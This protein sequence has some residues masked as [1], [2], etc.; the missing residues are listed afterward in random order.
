MN[1]RINK[2]DVQASESKISSDAQ[3][4]LCTRLEGQGT[5]V[6]FYDPSIRIA[7]LFHYLLPSAR[8]KENLRPYQY[9]DTG[10]EKTLFSMI[11]AGSE[12]DRIIIKISGA[13]VTGNPEQ[14]IF[15]VSMLAVKT[16]GN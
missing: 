9:A 16:N 15:R 3:D 7:G 8:E 14:D 13:A 5:A 10:I 2:M 11:D 12:W 4:V 6:M 1:E